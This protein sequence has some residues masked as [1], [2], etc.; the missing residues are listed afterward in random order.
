MKSSGPLVVVCVILMA[1]ALGGCLE[2]LGLGGLTRPDYRVSRTV[3]EPGGWMTDSA[4]TVQIQQEVPVEVRIEA[5][6]L[7]GARPRSRTG[8]SNLTMPVTMDIPDGTW[9]VT[10]FVDDHKWES[11]EGVRFDTLPPEITG[12]PAVVK[13]P[14]GSILLGD[15]AHVESGADLVVTQQDGTVV[16]TS[17]PLQLSGL[18]DGVHV[19]NLLATD[20]AGNE[21]SFAVQVI[22]GSATQLPEPKYTAGIVARYTTTLRL[23]D[24]TNLDD[25]VSPETARSSAP[26]FLGSGTGITPDD[27]AVQQVVADVVDDGMSTGEAALALY[28]WMYTNLEYTEDRLDEDDLL[29]PAQT[30]ANGGGV[31]R[32]LAALYASLL[33][34]AHIPA[35]LVAGYLAG[36]VNGFHAWV[37]FYGGVGPSPWVPVDVSGIDGPYTVS[38]MLQSFGIALPEHLALRALTPEEEQTDW[39]TAAILLYSSS[40]GDPVAPFLKDVELSLTRQNFCVNLATFAREA[41]RTCGTGFNAKIDNFPVFA[42]GVLDYGIEVQSAPRGTVLTLSIVYPDAATVAPDEVEYRTYFEPDQANTV[43]G[44]RLEEGFVEDPIRGRA[45]V[46]IKR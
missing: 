39:S 5:T 40:G 35:R 17:L 32:D 44:L 1:P 36:R 19:Y 7:D 33:R 6:S 41:R 42:T 4:F 34:A 22:S 16:G 29:D 21:A 30:I 46:K 11:F 14:T 28:E 12:L 25:F 10:Y 38:G 26:D 23:W 27:P 31:C 9:T 15:G 8:L 2:Q 20:A 18:S 24:L 13:A 45:D 3:L 43:D 37:E